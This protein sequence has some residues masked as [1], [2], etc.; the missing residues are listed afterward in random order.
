MGVLVAALAETSVASVLIGGIVPG[1]I[2]A[3]LYAGYILLKCLIDPSVAPPY[4]LLHVTRSEKIIPTLKYV[5]PLTLIIFSVTGVIFLGV[6]TPSEAA[7]T[8]SICSFFLAACYGK[9]GKEVI[10]KTFVETL[11]IALMI[12]LIISGA[13][14]FGQILSTSGASVGLTEMLTSLPMPPILIVIILQVVLIF[15]GM[16]A[17]QI[18]IIV[19]IIPLFIPVIKAFGMSPVWFC[20]LL[21][22]NIE[23]GATSPPYGMNLFV[24]KG[25]APPNTKMGDIY[26]AA[27]PYLYCD[28]ITM[29]LMIAF[30]MIVLWLPGLMR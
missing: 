21:I 8:G 29:A 22:L 30:P 27:M 9:L 4:E 3:I 23:I 24:M 14:V 11:R 5:L 15:L 13:V 19:V 2:M 17:G 16:F 7:A 28:A 25:V 20:L 10:K 26:R 18:P 6:A 1:M 12:L